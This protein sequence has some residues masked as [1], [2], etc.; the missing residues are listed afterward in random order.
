M[1][2]NERELN[3]AIRDLNIRVKN[4]PA[5]HEEL[6]KVIIEILGYPSVEDAH[7]H[8]LACNIGTNDLLTCQADIERK[9]KDKVAVF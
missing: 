1:L 3:R 2:E 9:I 8:H 6:N 4:D 7:K 5:D